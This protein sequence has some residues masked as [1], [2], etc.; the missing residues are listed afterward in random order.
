MNILYNLI[1]FVMQSWI[2]HDPS[3]IILICLFAAQEIFIIIIII[4][5]I[6]FCGNC[7]IFILHIIK[8]FNV[9]FDQFNASLLNRNLLT[10]NL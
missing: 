10:L 6:A 3:E 7:D 9:S 4:I 1:Y 2:S 8:V 5:K